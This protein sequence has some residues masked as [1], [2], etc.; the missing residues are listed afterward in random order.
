LSRH[1]PIPSP[2]RINSSASSSGSP[3]F[4]L[5]LSHYEDPVRHTPHDEG[6]YVW[7]Y[8]GPYDAAKEIEAKFPTTPAKVREAAVR[9]LEE[10]PAGGGPSNPP[11]GCDRWSG[12][13]GDWFYE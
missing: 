5:F 7:I 8:G 1:S 9:E 4:V 11:D 10:G 2:A 3:F 13:P 6:D 12:K